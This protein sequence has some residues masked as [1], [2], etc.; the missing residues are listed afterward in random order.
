MAYGNY[1][2][3][4]QI[5]T[6]AAGLNHSHNNTRSEPHLRPTPQLTGQ[7]LNPLSEARDQTRMFMGP[8]RVHYH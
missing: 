2:A 7:I 1:Q 8:S 3:R 4:G 5:G 6:I